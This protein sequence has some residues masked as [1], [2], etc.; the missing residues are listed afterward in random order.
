MNKLIIPSA[1]AATVLI[2]SIFAFMPV[3]KAGTIHDEIIANSFSPRVV[4]GTCN[5]TG[6]NVDGTM[7]TADGGPCDVTI[8]IEE[9]VPFQVVG[10]QGSITNRDDGERFEFNKLC[11]GPLFT[12]M[13]FGMD[14]FQGDGASVRAADDNIDDRQAVLGLGEGTVTM[15]NQV[16]E[17]PVIILGVKVFARSSS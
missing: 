10:V 14:D 13:G 8:D 16:K 3:E 15:D 5:T 2:A 7:D 17:D 1:L 12:K 4:T 6:D 11:Y 9:G